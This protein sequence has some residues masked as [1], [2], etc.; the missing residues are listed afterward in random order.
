MAFLETFQEAYSIAYSIRDIFSF[1]GVST[2]PVIMEYLRRT[3]GI[4][5]A[6]FLLGGISW[7]TVVAGI[8][9]KPSERDSRSNHNDQ[10]ET[11][12][13]RPTNAG[14]VLIDVSSLITKLL[15]AVIAIIR[16]LDISPAV[17]HPMFLAYLLTYFFFSYNFTV[18]SIFL[19]PLGTSLGFKPDEA[20]LFSTAGGIGGFFGKIV[21]L[22]L[23]Y[24]D[25]I[26]PFTAIVFPSLLWCVAVSF[27]VV[28]AEYVTLLLASAVTGFSLAYIDASIIGILPRY[29]CAVHLRQGT[30]MAFFY[31]GLGMQLGGIVTGTL[32]CFI[33][34][35]FI[36]ACKFCLA[37]LYVGVHYTTVYAM[38]TASAVLHTLPVSI[39]IGT[40]FPSTKMQRRIFTRMEKLPEHR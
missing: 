34:I 15:N 20:V 3:Y 21:V 33:N 13:D 8:L 16:F 22:L 30:V 1:L 32:C 27:Y 29:L 39:I 18:W 40:H 10:N 12:W 28:S 5:N 19:V 6:Y 31:G 17:R 11:N 9:I 14:K 36:T 25:K 2:M 37:I 26:N 4:H 35:S 7:N 23:F 24:F 38:C